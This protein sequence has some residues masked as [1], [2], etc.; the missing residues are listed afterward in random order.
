MELVLLCLGLFLGYFI[1]CNLGY[2]LKVREEDNK[3]CA[4][5]FIEKHGDS[6]HIYDYLTK[7]FIV[8]APEGKIAAALR[9]EI[10]QE[11]IVVFNFE[12]KSFLAMNMTT[13]KCEGLD[14]TI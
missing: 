12:N 1:G 11:N 8:Q 2:R 7:E 13:G 10:P 14:D 3:H 6:Y 5:L 4:V 9:K